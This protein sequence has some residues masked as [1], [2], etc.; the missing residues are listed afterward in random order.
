[1]ERSYDM[2]PPPAAALLQL[3][4]LKAGIT[5]AETARRAD[6]SVT[7]VSAYERGLRQPSLPT[8]MRLLRANGFELRLNLAPLDGHDDSLSALESRR[9]P[10][11]RARRD[12]QM[13][14]WREAIRLD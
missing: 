9:S 11:E 12:R 14:A 13:Q 6:V 7:M 10:T 8:L 2:V 4:R 5:Q 3:A 1:M